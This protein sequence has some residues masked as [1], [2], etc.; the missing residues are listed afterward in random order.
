M[1]KAVGDKLD[2]IT[3]ICQI[4]GA[5]E[6]GQI[7]GLMPQA[8][9]WQ[10]L[11]PNPAEECQFEEVDDGVY[12]MVL[13]CDKKFL[14]QRALAHT[15]PEAKTWRTKDLFVPHPSKPGLW[16]FHSRTDDIIVLNSSHKVW[17]IPMENIIAGHPLVAGALIVGNGRPEVLLLVEP[18]PG[19]ETDRMS[20]KEFIDAIWPKIA[21]ANMNSAEFGKIRRSRIVLSQPNLGFFRAPKG[22][23][24][25]KP[26][27]SLYA[28][29]ISAAFLDGTTDEQSE[30][31]ILEKHWIDEAKRFIGSIIHDMRADITLRDSDDF[32]V[33]KAMDSL[34]VLELGQKLRLSLLRR[35]DKDKNTINFWLR[36]IFEN[37]TIEDLAKATLDAVFGQGESRGHSNPGQ[38]VDLLVEELVSE[39]PEPIERDTTSAFAT[40]NLKVVLLGSRGRL[41]PFIVKDLLDDPRVTGIKCLDR[42]L[43]GQE[44]FQRRADELNIAIDA[45]DPKLQFVTA[46][47]SQPDF[48]LPQKELDEILNHADVIVHNV[49]AVNFAF[50]LAS[51]EHEMLK[52]VASLINMVNRAPARPRLVFMSSVSSTQSWS[53]VISPNIPVPEE[54]ISS[55]AVTMHTGYGQSKHVAERLLAAAGTQLKIPISILRVCQVAGPTMIAE[56]GKWESHDWMHSL[57]ILSKASGLVPTDMGNIDWIPVDKVSSIIR[58]LAL[59]EDAEDQSAHA[60]NVHLYNIV[61][62]NPIPFSAF[63]DALQRNISSSQPVSFEKWVEHLSELAPNKLSKDAEAERSR[64]L[65][66]FQSIVD[67]EFTRYSVEKAKN[68]SP[69]M[70]ELVPIEQDWLE[71]WCQQWT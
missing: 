38:E 25:R 34:T 67:E 22:T 10:Y 35:M 51:F 71:K 12:E 59:R 16:R 50:S 29:Y 32:F 33:S 19:P 9:D 45:K 42:G 55:P 15:F 47:L 58:D 3:D 18:R 52:S 31:G 69:T 64:I 39:L 46:D 43:D 40:E 66:W 2:D 41:G 56:G 5:L 61:H 26:T 28:E 4:Y 1:A 36:T 70:A 17:P 7:Q 14:G 27:E 6:M 49:W 63:S 60:L 13:N 21:E 68:A 54:V 8:G 65:P 44:A 57:A 20:K 11:E 23:I 53:K 48:K 62:P 30:I 37:P 24:S